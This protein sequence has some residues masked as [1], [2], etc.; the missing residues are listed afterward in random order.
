ML[1]FCGPNLYVQEMRNTH[2]RTHRGTPSLE[3]VCKSA[4][5]VQKHGNRFTCLFTLT[6][7]KRMFK[8]KQYALNI[9]KQ[10]KIGTE[11][12]LSHTNIHTP[13]PCWE[14]FSS[15]CHGEK[16]IM[17]HRSFSVCLSS[18]YGIKKD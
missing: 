7:S 8:S 1:L 2:T 5:E 14:P 11:I 3:Y 15:W 12:F 18:A 6:T 4:Q 9:Y 13:I 16:R 17:T 10:D